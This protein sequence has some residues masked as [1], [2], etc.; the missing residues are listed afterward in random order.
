VR[1]RGIRSY[2]DSAYYVEPSGAGVF[3]A[4]TSLWVAAL[5]QTCTGC[6]T[7]YA[8]SALVAAVTT[9][10]LTAMVVGPLGLSH[11]ALGNLSALH[12]YAGDPIA[13]R[14]NAG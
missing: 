2:S 11:T 9:R 8:G 7:T 5:N 1:C 10:L 14:V 4:G 13:A 6:V 12:E 3:H